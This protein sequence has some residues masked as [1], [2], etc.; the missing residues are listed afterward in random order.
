MI[1]M[2]AY[3]EHVN[4]QYESLENPLPA[5]IEILLHSYYHHHKGMLAVEPS[6]QGALGTQRL[7]Q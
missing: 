7:I 2:M 5:M 4:E 3:G 6:I 1:I